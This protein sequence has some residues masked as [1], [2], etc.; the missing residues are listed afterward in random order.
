M[1]LGTPYLIESDS[2]S[3]L[4]F[5]R[6]LVQS[7]SIAGK[8]Q[9]VGARIRA[10]AAE[11]FESFGVMLRS[12]MVA[13]SN[14][15][16]HMDWAPSEVR[17]IVVQNRDLLSLDAHAFLE[18]LRGDDHTYQA[19]GLYKA[20]LIADEWA[21]L[22]VRPREIEIRQLHA[23]ITN[24]ESHAGEYKRGFNE[25]AGAKH[26]PPAPADAAEGMRHLAYWLE[27]GSG[28]AALDATIVHAWLAHLHAFVDGNGRMARLLANL[29]LAQGGYP[30]LILSAGADRGEYYDA[31]AASDDGDILPLFDLFGR[32]LRRS[33]KVMSA[34]DYVENVIHDR[35][36]TSESTQRKLWERVAHKFMDALRDKLRGHSWD[37]VPQG[38]PSQQSFHFL[39]TMSADGNS[40]FLKIQDDLRTYPWLLWFGYNSDEY[41]E[42][43]NGP[44]GYP[45]IFFSVREENPEA[46]HPFSPVKGTGDGGAVSE[47]VLMAGKVKPARL[48]EGHRWSEYSIGEAA[49]RVAATLLRPRES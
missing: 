7:A 12:E 10:Q 14:Q 30:P 38:Y 18:G 1:L 19:L 34:A 3:A 5:N 37:V 36:L 33:V 25:I 44:S 26:K 35:L 28:D 11:I 21:E 47:L 43:Y 45:S 8:A 40:W 39:A 22:R 4:K 2:A 49:D 16:E 32:V 20:Q 42:V 48:Q 31:L 41:S 23:L 29:A 9:V 15:M 24:G 46:L 13:E 27:T 17:A 6:I